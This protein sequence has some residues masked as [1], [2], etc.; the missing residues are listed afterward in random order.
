MIILQQLIEKLTIKGAEI[1]VG[2]F[3]SNYSSLKDSTG[4]SVFLQSNILPAKLFLTHFCAHQAF[5]AYFSARYTKSLAPL[6]Y[7]MIQSLTKIIILVFWRGWEWINF[8]SYLCYV[9]QFI[10]NLQIPK[11]VDRLIIKC[12]G[13]DW[14]LRP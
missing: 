3:R 4:S 10:S 1:A 9:I 8:G 2:M 6:H 12:V 13:P 7:D 11:Y 14:K 5:W